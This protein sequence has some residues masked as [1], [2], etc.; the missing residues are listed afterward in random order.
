MAGLQNESR[1]GAGSG[2]LAE[3]DG[4]DKTFAYAKQTA[5]HHNTDVSHMQ[6]ASHQCDKTHDRILHRLIS[7][8]HRSAE[9][10]M[11]SD[12]ILHTL[13]YLMAKSFCLE[14]TRL[15]SA[16]RLTLEE[17]IPRFLQILLH[18]ESST[19]IFY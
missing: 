13:S 9:W 16:N 19:L 3:F 2:E 6:T 7:W 8:K 4:C 17:L 12:P 5:S 11:P 14:A 18:A 1:C 15:E 10:R